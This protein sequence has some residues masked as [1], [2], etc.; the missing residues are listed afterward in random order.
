MIFCGI[1]GYIVFEI[2]K[3]ECYFKL[4]D[5]WVFGCVLYIL[6]CGFL[7]FY[8]ESIEVFMEKVVKG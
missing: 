3:D 5:M 4:V 2:V 7:L 8:D 1:V 6:L